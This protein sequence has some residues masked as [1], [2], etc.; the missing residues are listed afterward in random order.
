MAAVSHVTQPNQLTTKRINSQITVNHIYCFWLYNRAEI[1]IV[2]PWSMI[3]A[4]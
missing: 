3:I 1:L 2:D 4:I